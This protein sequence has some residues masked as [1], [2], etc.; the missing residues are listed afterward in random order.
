MP[1]LYVDPRTLQASPESPKMEEDTKSFQNPLNSAESRLL[2]APKEATPREIFEALKEIPGLARDDLLRAYSLLIRSDRLFRALM[3]LPMDMRM[4]W[5]LIEVWPMKLMYF[6][7]QNNT[8]NM[9][10]NVS[11]E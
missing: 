7:A 11:V 5:L 8:S 9:L 4:E 3:A 10:H 6:A 2:E 1:L